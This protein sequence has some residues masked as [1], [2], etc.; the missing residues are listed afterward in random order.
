M[1]ISKTAFHYI[2]R[3]A[4][5]GRAFQNKHPMVGKLK[6]PVVLTSTKTLSS[7]D[8]VKKILMGTQLMWYPKCQNLAVFLVL[9]S[10]SNR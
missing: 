8:L 6:L 1:Y 9:I 2:I 4:K 7:Q 5:F 10:A 3:Y